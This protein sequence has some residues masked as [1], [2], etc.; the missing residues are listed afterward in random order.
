MLGRGTDQEG[1]HGSLVLLVQC[2]SDEALDV[3]VHDVYVG[4][5]LME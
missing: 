3:L 5:D 2:G 4:V 1:V